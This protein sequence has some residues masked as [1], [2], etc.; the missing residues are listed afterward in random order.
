MKGKRNQLTFIACTNHLS[1]RILCY[2]LGLVKY[3]FFTF[4]RFTNRLLLANMR[5]LELR[6]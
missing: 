4:L 6:V 2:F 3:I 5:E 1:G